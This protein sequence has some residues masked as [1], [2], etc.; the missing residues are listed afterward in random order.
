MI[1][2]FTQAEIAN[3]YE[4]KAKAAIIDK[5]LDDYNADSVVRIKENNKAAADPFD[6]Y[7]YPY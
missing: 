1:T 6:Q 3:D 7:P 4:P 2:I 5:A